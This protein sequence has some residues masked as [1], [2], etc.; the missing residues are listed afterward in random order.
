MDI[1][2]TNI[3]MYMY[4]CNSRI[5]FSMLRIIEAD[6]EDFERCLCVYVYVYIYIYIYSKQIDK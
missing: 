6:H 3:Y 1:C 4:I 2:N 5:M